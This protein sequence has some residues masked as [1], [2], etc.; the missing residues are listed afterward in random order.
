MAALMC[1]VC[2]GHL[3]MDSSGD[4]STCESCGTKYTVETMRSMIQALSEVELNVKGIATV[5]SLI[6][7]ARL[8]CEDSRFSNAHEIIEQAL[9]V[10]PENGEAYL[11]AFMSEC[12]CKYEE[13]LGDLLSGLFSEYTNYKRAQQFGDISL[14]TRLDAYEKQARERYFN[15]GRMIMTPLTTQLITVKSP[16]VGTFYRA[17]APNKPPY[18]EVGDVVAAGQTLCIVEA[19]KLMNEIYAEQP[20]IVRGICLENGQMVN[21]NNDLFLIEPI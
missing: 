13:N 17:P 6:K 16:V 14:R 15:T 4:Y 19:M 21:F 3:Q 5:D 8:M 7:R 18:V 12:K 2:G 9:S 1:K 10:D 11:I 20:G